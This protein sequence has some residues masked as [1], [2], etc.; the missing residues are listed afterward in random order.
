M[1]IVTCSL[2]RTLVL[3]LACAAQKSSRQLLSVL[4][5]TLDFACLSIAAMFFSGEIRSFFCPW[6]RTSGPTAQAT[7]K[8]FLDTSRQDSLR[9][10]RVLCEVQTWVLEKLVGHM[11]RFRVMPFKFLY[12]VMSTELNIWKQ[13]GNMNMKLNTV[14]CKPRSYIPSTRIK[15]TPAKCT[16]APIIMR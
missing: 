4:E 13:K 9:N 16:P 7:T 6:G 2:Q 11:L 5:S 12:R 10:I 3:F 14:I 1:Q 8:T 15:Q